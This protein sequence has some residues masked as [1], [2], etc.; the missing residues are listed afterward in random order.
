[1]RGATVLKYNQGT[2]MAGMFS[3]QMMEMAQRQFAQM[4]PDQQKQMFD[5]VSK[6]DPRVMQNMMSGVR[7]C[8]CATY[9][10]FVSA[11]LY[12]SFGALFS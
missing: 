2:K 6:M 10:Q 3:P 8:S 5:Q 12:C 7:G 1:M 4:T 9:V 11:P